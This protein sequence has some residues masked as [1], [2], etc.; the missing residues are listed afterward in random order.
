MVDL[1]EMNE[2]IHQ[3][4]QGNEP[5]DYD[6]ETARRVLEVVKPYWQDGDETVRNDILQK[7][8]RLEESGV[9]FPDNYQQS[10]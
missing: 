3:S 4:L 1:R 8:S 6:A 5:E 9:P 10:L 7:L 2:K